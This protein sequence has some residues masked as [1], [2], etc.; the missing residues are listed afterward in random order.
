MVLTINYEAVTVNGV[1]QKQLWDV[2]I[3]TEHD[4]DGNMILPENITSRR[5]IGLEINFTDNSFGDKDPKKGRIV[6]P[7]VQHRS[8]AH[9]SL[10]LISHLTLFSIFLPW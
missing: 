10:P 8:P 7:L 1:K 6:D 4:E 5:I 3:N 9:P 2:V